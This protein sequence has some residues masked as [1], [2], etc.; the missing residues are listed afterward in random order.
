MREKLIPTQVAD[1]WHTV[2]PLTRRVTKQRDRLGKI[3]LQRSMII[4]LLFQPFKPFKPH[5]ESSPG[6]APFPP[7]R[8]ADEGGGLNEP[9]DKASGQT[10]YDGCQALTRNFQA[11]CRIACR[12]MFA[13]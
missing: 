13:R 2:K 1:L 4:A 7:P 11:A 9:F 6:Q 8:H 10:F 3:A 5:P 12:A